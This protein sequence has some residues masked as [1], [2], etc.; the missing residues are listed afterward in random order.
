MAKKYRLS[1]DLQKVVTAALK[2]PP[3]EQTSCLVELALMRDMAGYHLEHYDELRSR[4]EDELN[5]ANKDKLR[6]SLQSYTLVMFEVTEKVVKMAKIVA[7]ID[8]SGKDHISPLA[9]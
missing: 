3:Y 2:L 7:D 5:E 9:M 1:E 8:A 4:V 6:E